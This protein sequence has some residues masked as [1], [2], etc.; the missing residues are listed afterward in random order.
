LELNYSIIIPYQHSPERE[1]LLYACL[2]NL[3]R[4]HSGFEVC[5]HEIGVSQHFKHPSKCKYLFTK[6]SGPFHRAWAINRGVRELATGNMLVLMDGD[7]IVNSDWVRELVSCKSLS[8]GWGKLSTLNAEGTIHYLRTCHINKSL[9]EKTKTPSMGGAAG[10]ITVIPSSLF[11]SIK[12]IP[13]DFSGSWGGEDNA[14]WAKLNSV[15]YKVKK[16][17]SEI[18]HLSHSPSTPRVKDIQHKIFQMIY[19]SPSQW[20]AYLESIGD[21]WGSANPDSVILPSHNFIASSNSCSLP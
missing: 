19:W 6:F 18:F 14:L 16:F 20:T 4:L 3:F 7:L 17:S 10:G 1:P 2:E 11:Y 21:S 8:V 9:I 15:G 5:I 13:E 12:G